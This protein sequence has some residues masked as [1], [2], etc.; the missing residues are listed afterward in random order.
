MAQAL[1]WLDRCSRSSYTEELRMHCCHALL[2]VDSALSLRCRHQC[3]GFQ[4]R[5]ELL[6][7]YH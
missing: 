1:L 7:I 5:P 2:L 4:G 3:H 6:S